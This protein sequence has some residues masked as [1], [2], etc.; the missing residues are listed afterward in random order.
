M[1]YW[2]MKSEPDCFGID[3]LEAAPD[4]VEMWDGVRNY[5]VRNMIRDHMRPGD[6]A[7]FYHS[8]T[9]TPGVVGVMEIAGE[10]YPDPTAFDPEDEH[11]DPKSDSDRPRWYC[12]DVRFVEKWPRIVA[13]QEMRRS[14]RLEGL[15]LLRKGNRLSIVPVTPDQWAAIR[16]MAGEAK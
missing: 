7:F 16:E 1:N 9:K 13:L 4:G 12:V 10:A 3:D 2:L 5:Q 11:Y 15:P 8:N 6:R 14:P